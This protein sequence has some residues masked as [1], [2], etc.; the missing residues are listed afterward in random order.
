MG[1]TRLRCPVLPERISPRCD[2]TRLAMSRQQQLT[3]ANRKP[4]QP[5]LAKVNLTLSRRV[6]PYLGSP[7]QKRLTVATRNACRSVSRLAQAYPTASLQK[8][9]TVATRMPATPR[10]DTTL[11]TLSYPCATLL[12]N[13]DLRSPLEMPAT[14]DLG[15]PCRAQTRLVPPN[16]VA[17]HRINSALRAPIESQR[18]FALSCEA[19][20][21]LDATK[22]TYGGQ[23]KACGNACCHDMAYLS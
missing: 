11:R 16:P 2:A 5:C 20:A 18:R 9:L 15:L 21:Y 14:A 7:Q 1:A 22:A 19:I 10:L 13:S 23:S 17:A 4:A 8:R 6:A 3:V 12:N